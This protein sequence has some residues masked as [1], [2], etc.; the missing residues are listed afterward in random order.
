MEAGFLPPNLHYKKCRDELRGL[1]EGRLKVATEVIP[2]T[3]E[4]ASVNSFGIGGTNANVLMKIHSKEKVD[5]GVPCD[6]LPRLVL[7]S[8]R[9]E[10]AVEH[11][12][13]EV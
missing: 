2:W 10:E 9:T 13:K 11:M 7:G 5:N 8:G 1:A 12:L 4:Y 3:F 6:D